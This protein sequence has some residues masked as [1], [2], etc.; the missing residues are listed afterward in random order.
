MKSS[1]SKLLREAIETGIELG[2][3]ADA[4]VDMVYY[5]PSDI[6]FVQEVWKYQNGDEGLIIDRRGVGKR[7][8][9]HCYIKVNSLLIAEQIYNIADFYTC[10]SA[11]EAKSLILAQTLSLVVLTGLLSDKYPQE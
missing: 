9:G 7:N 4:I 11:E 3:I 1:Y 6:G 5:S 2:F 10:V 8:D